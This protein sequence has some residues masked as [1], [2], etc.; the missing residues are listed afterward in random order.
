MAP[1]IT[2]AYS[3]FTA[4]RWNKYYT[5]ILNVIGDFPKKHGL[6][7]LENGDSQAKAEALINQPTFSLVR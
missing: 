1:T 6:A 7:K 3:S 2:P 4:L 5:Y